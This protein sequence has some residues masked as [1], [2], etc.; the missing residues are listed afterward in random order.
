VGVVLTQFDYK[1]FGGIALTVVFLRAI[2]LDN[3]LRHS[4]NDFAPVR[5]HEGGA[6][7]LMAV[8]AG[9]GAVVRVQP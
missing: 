1:T 9:A 4:W 6:Q 8:G 7:H 2:L 3:R 5:V